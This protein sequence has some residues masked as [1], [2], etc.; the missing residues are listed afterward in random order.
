MSKDSVKS[1]G[2]DEIEMARDYN[3]IKPFLDEFKLEQYEMIVGLIERAPGRILV[4][5][6][7]DMAAI[8]S[9]GS[10]II[11][12]RSKHAAFKDMSVKDLTAHIL[13]LI[14]G[15][16]IEWPQWSLSCEYCG[17]PLMQLRYAF[18]EV[19]GGA[20]IYL[21]PEG[22]AVCWERNWTT[23]PLTHSPSKAEL[24][25]NPES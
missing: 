19:M 1:L 18:V 3:S 24:E 11:L 17:R 8:L 10:R 22:I 4:N 25:K 23:W 2:R 20:V 9:R 16:L 7:G 15:T 14:E 5:H 13:E 21:D 6:T 12:V